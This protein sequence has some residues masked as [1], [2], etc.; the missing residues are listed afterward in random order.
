MLKGT[1][2]TTDVGEKLT[3]W[4]LVAVKVELLGAFNR[5]LEPETKP[6]PVMV[7]VWGLAEVMRLPGETFVMEGAAEPGEIWK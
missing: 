1:D 7:S 4:L 3:I 5:T 6:L 2:T